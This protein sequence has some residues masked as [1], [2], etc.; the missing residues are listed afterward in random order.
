MSHPTT[1]SLD[2]LLFMIAILLFPRLVR[3]IKLP[4]TYTVKMRGYRRSQN[5]A[6]S[7]G[8]MNGTARLIRIAS[9][10]FLVS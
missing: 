9:Y 5:T 3:A 1:A 7:R 2:A 6:L 4:K 10:Q 8:G